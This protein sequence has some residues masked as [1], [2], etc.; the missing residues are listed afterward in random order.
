MKPSSVPDNVAELLKTVLASPAAASTPALR[1]TVAERAADLSLERSELTAIP[2][3]LEIYVGKVA[4]SAHKVLDS[5]VEA[6]RATGYSVDEV[7]EITVAAAIG[8]GLARM[9]V[10]LAA[11]EEEGR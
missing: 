9:N 4:R 2:Q 6:L 3:D 11:L 7:F 1:Q 5:D 10:A 8:A